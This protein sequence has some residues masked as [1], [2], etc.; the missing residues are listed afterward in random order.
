MGVMLR[1]LGGSLL[2]LGILLLIVK[3]LMMIAWNF[4]IPLI[5]VGVILSVIGW[6]M[7]R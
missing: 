7:M 6:G 2:S 1:V 5:L 4:A 3:L